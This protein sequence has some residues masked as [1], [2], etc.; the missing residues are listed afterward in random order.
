MSLNNNSLK[1]ND[2]VR[3][4]E[5]KYVV[6]K[7]TRQYLELLPIDT[8]LNG[9]EVVYFIPKI[10]LKKSD[11]VEHEKVDNF[12]LMYLLNQT[13]PLIKEILEEYLESERT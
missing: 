4:G 10:T 11:V 8:M 1:R 9:D 3:F 6:Y 13:N 12:E 2:V 5:Y 7:S